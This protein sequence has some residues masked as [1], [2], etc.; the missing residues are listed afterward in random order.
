[1]STT[2][3]GGDQ[4]TIEQAP[5]PAPTT[6]YYENPIKYNWERSSRVGTITGAGFGAAAGAA[7]GAAGLFI[8]AVPGSIIGSLVGMVVGAGAGAAADAAAVSFETGV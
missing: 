8:G 5:D 4:H 6:V 2:P 3:H 1:M 7:I